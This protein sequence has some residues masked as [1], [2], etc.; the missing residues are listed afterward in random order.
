LG[1]AAR[2]KAQQYL[3]VLRAFATPQTAQSKDVLAAWD[4]FCVA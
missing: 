1:W 4:L 2:R 3:A